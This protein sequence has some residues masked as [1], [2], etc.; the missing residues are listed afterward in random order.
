MY[1]DVAKQKEANRNHAKAY[2]LRKK[3]MTM[4][5]TI[6]PPSDEGMT[7]VT[8]PIV[9]Q[10]VPPPKSVISKLVQMTSAPKWQDEKS[11][12]MRKFLKGK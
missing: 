6:M 8:N 4:G 2:R 12:Y 7:G 11:D 9:M 3:G 10:E 1:K 5:M